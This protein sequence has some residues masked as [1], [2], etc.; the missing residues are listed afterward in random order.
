MK[1]ILIIIYRYITQFWLNPLLT[2]N[3]IKNIWF[4]S[5]DYYK[6]KKTSKNNKNFKIKLN[7]PCLHDIYNNWW[8]SKWHYF[9]QDLLIAKKIYKQ[10]PI[11]HIDIWSRVDWFIT[12]LATFREVEVFDIRPLESKTEWIIFKQANL[13]NLDEKYINYTESISSLHAIEHFWLGRY[14]DPI[15]INGH[16]K[17]LDNIYKILKQWW[18]FYFS[19][20]IWNQRIEFNA[21]RV[22]SIKYLLNLFESKYNLVSFNY[23]DDNWDLY[24][25]IDPKLWLQDNFNCNFGCWIFELIKK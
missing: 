9:H 1:N 2:F 14:W 8:T 24:E 19:T 13:M 25:N 17:W 5:R 21:H 3:W 23:V 7:Y 6:I 22:F 15:D 18:K 16:I 10:N 11:K 20:P 4:Y 12:H